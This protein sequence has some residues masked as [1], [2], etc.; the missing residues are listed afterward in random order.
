M[1]SATMAI[2]ITA[3]LVSKSRN[4]PRIIGIIAHWR[5]LSKHFARLSGRD[6]LG[7]VLERLS[8]HLRRPHRQPHFVLAAWAPINTNIRVCIA[9]RGLGASALH[10]LST[11]AIRHLTDC[12]RRQLFKNS[13]RSPRAEPNSNLIQ[14][15]AERRVKFRVNLN[16]TH[17][18]FPNWTKFE[19][20]K[21]DRAPDIRTVAGS[22]MLIHV[23]RD[24]DA[25]CCLRADGQ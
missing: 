6:F 22:Q 15:K 16:V 9:R 18:I 19:R 17:A 23:V 2:F 3:A 14:R 4:T 25:I 1:P 5:G 10:F 11:A 13:H 20:V 21:I 24:S 8:Q 7:Q 12:G